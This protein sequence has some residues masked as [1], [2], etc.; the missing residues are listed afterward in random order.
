M[1]IEFDKQSW[2]RDHGGSAGGEHPDWHALRGRLCAAYAAHR[3][4]SGDSAPRR[5]AALTGSFDREGAALLAGFGSSLTSVNLDPSEHGKRA[6][7]KDDP[8]AGEQSFGG[9]G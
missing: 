8:A 9:R 3:V 2:M 7:G 5:H 6:E 1:V 4:V